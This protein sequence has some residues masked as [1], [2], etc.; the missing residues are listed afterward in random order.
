MCELNDRKLL[1]EARK[2]IYDDFKT[3]YDLIQSATITTEEKIVRLKKLAGDFAEKCIAKQPFTAYRK[4]LLM[5]II[6]PLL[7]A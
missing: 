3:E 2:K 1:V 7:A 4:Y 5:N 6:V